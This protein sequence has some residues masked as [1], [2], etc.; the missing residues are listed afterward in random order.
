MEKWERR[1]QKMSKAR[2]GMQVK[3]RNIGTLY[4]SAVKKQIKKAQASD[5]KT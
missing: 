5:G 1:D 2:Y 4:V 3:G